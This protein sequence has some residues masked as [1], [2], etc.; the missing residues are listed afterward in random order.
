MC[1]S[2]ADVAIREGAAGQ[3]GLLGNAALPTYIIDMF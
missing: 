1:S 2:G 3:G